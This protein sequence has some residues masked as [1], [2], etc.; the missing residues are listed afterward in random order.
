[1]VKRAWEKEFG[2]FADLWLRQCEGY[3]TGQ[4]LV[5]GR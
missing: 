3:F 4:S 5:I 2:G 1:M